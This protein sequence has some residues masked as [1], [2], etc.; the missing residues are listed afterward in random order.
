MSRRRSFG[1]RHYG[2]RTTPGP[3]RNSPPPTVRPTNI[4]GLKIT[5]AGGSW[6][7]GVVCCFVLVGGVL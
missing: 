6:C 3:S 7:R 4:L 5:F 1:F 2:S